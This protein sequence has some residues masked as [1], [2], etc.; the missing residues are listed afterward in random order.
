MFKHFIASKMIHKTKQPSKLKRIEIGPSEIAL[1]E[2]STTPGVLSGYF[3]AEEGQTFMT[4]AENETAV[5]LYGQPEGAEEAEETTG[6]FGYNHQ[7][8]SN[9]D[10]IYGGISIHVVATAGSLPF[11]VYSDSARTQAVESSDLVNADTTYYLNIDPSKIITP[12]N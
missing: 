11:S 5:T 12:T 8:S 3:Y 2:G 9:P 1:E 10:I 6:F 7:V 4:L